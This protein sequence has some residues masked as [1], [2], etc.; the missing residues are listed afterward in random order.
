MLGAIIGDVVGSRFEFNHG[1][2][3]RKD[4]VLVNEES[5]FTDDTVLTVAL[6]DWAL[7]A[8]TKEA[9]SAVEF[10]QKW[11][12]KYPNRG[13]GCRFNN[14][15]HSIDPKPYGSIGNGSGMRVSPIAYTAKTKEEVLR[16]SDLVTGVTHNGYNGL[17]GARLIA[18]AT[19]MALHGASKE[20]IRSM[21]VS[22]YPEIN[23]FT[24]DDLVKHYRFNE[25]AKTTCPQAV[26][27]FLISNSFEDC[28]RTSISIGGDSDTLAAMSMAIAEA[29]YKNIPHE[30]YDAVWNKLDKDIQDIVIEFKNKYEKFM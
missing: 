30:I 24:Y 5:N 4:F 20:E 16:L 22:M 9:T 29:Y 18:L 10:I 7:H 26:Y 6:M 8:E 28:L 15:L 13:Y 17:K 27:C 3:P 1:P 14:W 2:K 23:S 19:F 12:K 11:G 21:A 25:L